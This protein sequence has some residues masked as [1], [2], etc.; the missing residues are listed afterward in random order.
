MKEPEPETAAPTEPE[1]E[2]PTEP[3]ETQEP[4]SGA[5]DMTVPATETAPDTNEAQATDPVEEKGCGSVISLAVLCMMVPAA[6]AF[7]FKR[8]D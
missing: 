2:A 4:V 7:V 5:E 6:L 8:E 3:V 1:T